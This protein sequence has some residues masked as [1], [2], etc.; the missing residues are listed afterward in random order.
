MPTGDAA[1]PSLAHISLGS[2]DHQWEQQHSSPARHATIDLASARRYCGCGNLGQPDP[3]PGSALISSMAQQEHPR[4]SLTRL[5]PS[6]GS[7]VW[8]QVLRPSLAH[9]QPHHSCELGGVAAQLGLAVTHPVPTCASVCC[10]LT[11][12]VLS[13]DLAHTY[14]VSCSD[15]HCGHLGRESTKGRKISPSLPCSVLDTETLWELSTQKH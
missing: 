1:L 3:A 6:L 11:F 10:R 8:Q 14:Y 12:P 15:D 9:S 7:Y 13:S 2:S 4:G 5:A